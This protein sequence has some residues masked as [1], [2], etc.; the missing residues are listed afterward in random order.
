MWSPFYAGASIYA[1]IS[2]LPEY[3][4]PYQVAV[5]GTAVFY[6]LWIGFTFCKMIG[7]WHG[8]IPYSGVNWGHIG[9]TIDLIM[10][11]PSAYF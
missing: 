1:K 3:S 7:Y 6:L 2:H 4:T 8:S 5:A 11:N 9:N 10:A